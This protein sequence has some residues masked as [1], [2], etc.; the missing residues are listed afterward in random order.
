MS[1]SRAKKHLKKFGLEDRIVE[2]DASTATV[3]LAAQAIGCIPARI[4]KTMSFKLD[5]RVFLIV[6]AGDAKINNGKYKNEF[7][8]KAKMLAF[9]E[10]EEQVGHGVGGVCP[11]GVK[12]AVEVYLDESLKRFESVYPACGSENSLIELTIGEL[13][14]CSGYLK[15][16]DVCKGW[17]EEEN[18]V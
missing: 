12:E 11:F 7:G 13:E 14:Q 1:V 2:V 4:A 17:Y 3:E 16:V 6:T 8:G 5:E 10:V 15:W 18:M 9:E